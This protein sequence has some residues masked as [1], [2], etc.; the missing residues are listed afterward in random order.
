LNEG[1]QQDDCCHPRFEGEGGAKEA[2]DG[3]LTGGIMKA[4][5]HADTNCYRRPD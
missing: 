2:C 4:S 5:V 1:K 3:L